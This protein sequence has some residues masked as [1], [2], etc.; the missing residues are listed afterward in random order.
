MSGDVVTRA[1]GLTSRRDDDP[2]FAAYRPDIGGCLN[3]VS[4]DGQ[5]TV[6]LALV[7]PKPTRELRWDCGC[8]QFGNQVAV[9]PPES[10]A[11]GQG[12]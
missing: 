12:T 5:G 9:P 7:C 2:R 4:D 3:A 8:C 10:A 6:D 1:Q 11:W